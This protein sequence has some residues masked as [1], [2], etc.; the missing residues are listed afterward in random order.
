MLKNF[1]EGGIWMRFVDYKC[2]DCKTICEIVLRSDNGSEIVCEKCGSS[3]MVRIFAPVG[4]KSSSGSSSSDE[5]STGSSSSRGSCSGG[6][7]SSCSGCG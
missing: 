5:F 7:C 3:N 6:S 4:F 2:S 1:I